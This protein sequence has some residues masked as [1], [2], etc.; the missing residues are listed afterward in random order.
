M[1]RNAFD[2]SVVVN[3]G[4]PDWRRASALCSLGGIESHWPTSYPLA[5]YFY[6]VDVGNGRRIL[7]DTPKRV[8]DWHERG[9]GVEKP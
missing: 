2:R 6:P 4:I 3:P 1:N 5:T 7:L 9:I 8:M